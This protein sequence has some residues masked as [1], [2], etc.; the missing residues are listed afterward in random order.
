MG[1]RKYGEHSPRVTSWA[2]AQFAQRHCCCAA[3]VDIDS[4]LFPAMKASKLYPA[5]SHSNQ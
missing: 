2:A 5:E 3:Q 4:A 1:N